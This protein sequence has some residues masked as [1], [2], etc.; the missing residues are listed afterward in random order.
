MS[1]Y[2][3]TFAKYKHAHHRVILDRAAI[4]ETDDLDTFLSDTEPMDVSAITTP[5]AEVP[6]SSSE[7]TLSCHTPPV[8]TPSSRTPSSLFQ[9]GQSA[10]PSSGEV[11]RI[12]SLARSQSAHVLPSSTGMGVVLGGVAGCGGG[13][14]NDSLSVRKGMPDPR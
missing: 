8:D 6:A 3:E 2:I 1:T 11:T 14:A 5:L 12:S 10:T 7:S 13:T 4:S 9:G